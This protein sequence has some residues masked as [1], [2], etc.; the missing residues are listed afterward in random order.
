M[1]IKKKR[2][3][4]VA[5]EDREKLQLVAFKADAEVMDALAELERAISTAGMVVGRRSQAIRSAILEA[6]DRL[7]R[8]KLAENEIV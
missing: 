6:R 2:G 3:R 1:T 4:P 5:H 8:T 7:R